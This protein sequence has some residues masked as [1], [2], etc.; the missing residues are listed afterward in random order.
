MKKNSSDEDAT[1][2]TFVN[3]LM[4]NKLFDKTDLVVNNRQ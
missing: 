3:E 2:D 4:E 1:E